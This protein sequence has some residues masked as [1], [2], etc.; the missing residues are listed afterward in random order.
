MRLEVIDAGG[1][2]IVTDV[3]PTDQVAV[4]EKEYYD[5]R[6]IQNGSAWLRRSDRHLSGV[7]N[8]MRLFQENLKELL[9]KARGGSGKY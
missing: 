5:G 9:Q 7:V 1:G 2:K 6:D 4:D 8:L 3:R